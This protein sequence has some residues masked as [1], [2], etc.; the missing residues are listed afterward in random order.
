MWFLKAIGVL[1]FLCAATLLGMLVGVVTITATT[2]SVT[3]LMSSMFLI[4]AGVAFVSATV[5]ENGTDQA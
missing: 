5:E 3:F 1:M 2:A 4:I